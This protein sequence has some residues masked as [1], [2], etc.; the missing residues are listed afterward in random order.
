VP[1]VPDHPVA[2]PDLVVP[3]S[4]VAIS[5]YTRYSG[6]LFLP[7]VGQR[8]YDT[9]TV[10]PVGGYGLVDAQGV[11][12][13]DVGGHIYNH[14]VS[15]GA[16]AIENINSYRLT[17]NQAYLDI[18]VRNGQRLI[19]TH[20]ESDGAW[21]FPYDFDFAVVGDTSETLRAPWYS[22][23]AQGRA[24]STFVRLYQATGD[25]KWRDA[26]DSTFASLNQ[27]PSGSAPY[28]VHL[29]AQGRLWLEEYPR[30]PVADSE[31]VLNGHIYALFGLFDYW[32]LTNSTVAQDLIR[33]AINTVAQTAMSQ[34]RRVNAS[35][36]YSLR[37]RT[38]AGTYHQIHVTQML[39]LLAYKHNTS[40]ATVATAFRND[41]PLPSVTGTMQATAHTSTIYQATSAGV[42]SGS[43]RV[44]FAGQTTAPT[45]HRLRLSGGPIALRVSAG[46]YTGWWFPESYGV[47]WLLGATDT[48]A[49][50]PQV[51]VY[52]EPGTF[53]AYRLDAAG[54]V[55]GSR[56]VTFTATSTAPSVASAIVG[57]RP[58]Y[59][60]TVGAYAGY[61]LPMAAGIHL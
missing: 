9:T 29:D 49:Y 54:R 57:G 55:A 36:V 30:N 1:L 21:Y 8:P 24:L 43:K 35:S 5:G 25:L 2:R 37:H 18:A 53:S 46:P 59:H 15:Q 47:T 39:N 4:R 19:D 20:T 23:M 26:A 44:S 3:G 12:M 6:A 58:A 48:H 7:P 11:R 40:F 42:I 28:G 38:P 31:E 22:G 14:P 27:A 16:Y 13:A 45:D 50:T 17:G 61:W 60:F 10:T 32:Q 41:Y 33:G 51:K 34:F 52:I 56:S